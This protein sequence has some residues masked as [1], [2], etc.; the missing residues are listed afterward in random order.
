MNLGHLIVSA[1]KWNEYYSGK[2]K[3]SDQT[4]R[5]EREKAPR[6]SVYLQLISSCKKQWKIH[7]II[8]DFMIS[9]ELK[10]K[11]SSTQPQI[12]NSCIFSSF[13]LCGYSVWQKCTSSAQKWQFCKEPSCHIN[14]SPLLIFTKQQ[15]HWYN[16]WCILQ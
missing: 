8:Y 3:K 13:M 12:K 7:I 1:W 2:E 6:L 11:K 10:E 15:H 16:G 5:R 4:R 14:S 9:V